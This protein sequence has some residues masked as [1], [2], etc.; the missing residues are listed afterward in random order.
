MNFQTRVRGWYEG[1]MVPHENAPNS[2]VFLGWSHEHH[3]TAKC[4]RVLIR[5]YLANWQWLFGTLI[6]ALSLWVAVLALR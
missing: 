6:G 1:K 3:W 5:F 2:E 4:A